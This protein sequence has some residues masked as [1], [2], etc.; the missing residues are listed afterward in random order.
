MSIVKRNVLKLIL[1]I[2][3]SLTAGA[4]GSLFTVSSIPTWY[5]TLNKPTFSPPNWV[6]GPVWTT[7]YILM[8]VSLY[9]IF[10]SKSKLKQKGL[11]LFF[12]QLALN[13]AWS[14]VFFGMKNPSLAFVNIIALWITILLTIKIFYK[15]NKNSAYLLYPYLLWVSFASLLNLMIVV[16]N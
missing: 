7:L 2:G 11:T 9:W 10:M 8:G 3:I 5:S 16:L 14:I 15:I 4:V 12:V 1:S 6:F 13:T